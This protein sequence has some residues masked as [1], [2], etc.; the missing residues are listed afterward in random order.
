VGTDMGT[1]M[2]PTMLA[3]LREEPGNTPG[4]VSDVK[5]DGFVGQ[6]GCED[7]RDDP[8]TRSS[9]NER[10]SVDHTRG[11]DIGKRDC[12]LLL[13]NVSFRAIRF[14]A[15]GRSSQGLS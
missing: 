3:T 15:C 11:Y 13:P 5:D 8:R 12:N 10:A 6:V 7:V 4:A 9:T 1:D 14:L 2:E